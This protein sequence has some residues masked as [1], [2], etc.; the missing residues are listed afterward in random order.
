MKIQFFVLFPE[1]VRRKWETY[2]EQMSRAK[3][4]LQ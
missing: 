1:M 2:K 3:Q 4:L